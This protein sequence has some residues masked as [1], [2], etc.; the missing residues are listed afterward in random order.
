MDVEHVYLTR[1]VVKFWSAK[2]VKMARRERNIYKRKDGRFEARYVKG[3]DIHGRAIYGA[4]YAR[5]YAAVKE[6]LEF[7]KESMKSELPPGA[8]QT[9]VEVLTCHL[10]GMRAQ[11]KRSTFDSYRRYLENHI[12]PYF[13]D[14][15]CG[16][17]NVDITQGFVNKLIENGLSAATVQSVFSFLRKGLDGVSPSNV[18]DVKLPKRT[19]HE[20]E[21]LS[22]GEQRR[23]EAVA[24]TS[25][26]IDR[27][28]IILCL[29]T[30]IRIGELCGLMWSDLDFDRSQLYIQRTIQRVK[31]ISDESKT[32][33]VFLAPKTTSSKRCIPLPSFLLTLLKEHH[34]LSKGKYIISREGSA[35]EPRNLQYRF[36][37]L[38]DTANLRP[39]NFHVTRHTFATRALENGFDV[40][41]LSEIL[42]HSSPTITL[43][44][45]A[46]TLDEHKRKSMESL[47]SLYK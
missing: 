18:F 17:L 28:G 43:K 24:K 2:E 7:A 3:R 12:S 13:K 42:G 38:L 31:S 9:V 23:L 21:V 8:K 46:H 41:T 44:K 19:G 36:K 25:D 34:S 11:I 22:L 40:K 26:D 6:K 33:I 35:I 20:A 5:S 27:I 10:E 15:R 16:K 29:Y 47:S 1:I 32:Q 14:I 4:V 39:V 45:Y 30:G 37:R